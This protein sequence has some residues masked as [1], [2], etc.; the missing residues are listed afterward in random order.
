MPKKS[1]GQNFLIDHNIARK[2][3]SIISK[4]K[5]CNII[6]I[7]PGKGFLTDYLIKCDYK[8]ILLIEKDRF[9]FSN[10]KKKYNL[11]NIK[12]VNEDVL[13]TKEIS[14]ISKPK[15]IVSNLP[16]NISTKVI[17]QYLSKINEY[18][19]LYFMVQK[20]VAERL[21]FKNNK[22]SNR[23]NL[24]AN[25]MSNYEKVF[26]ISPNVFRPRPKVISSFIPQSKG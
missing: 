2:I 19:G 14:K 17:I 4:H 13:I 16:Y 10:L 20:E 18:E 15:I 24:I 22:K 1:L 3:I 12:L 5:K 7:G 9:L 8:R 6:E 25:L 21:K 26:D 23:L 11:K